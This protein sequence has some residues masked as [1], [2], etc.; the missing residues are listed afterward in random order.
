MSFDESYG[1]A[2]E[3]V[4]QLF[5]D[6]VAPYVQDND[7]IWVHDYHLM[8][9]AKK[10]RNATKDKKNV[11]IGFFLHTA[12]PSRDF[13]TIL[14]K[15]E[16]LLQGLFSCDL[17][18]FHTAEYEEHF[19]NSCQSILKCDMSQKGLVQDGSKVNTG[20]FPIGID[21]DEFRRGLDEPE[22]QD[23]LKKL[24][25]RFSGQR[26]IVGV[27]RMDYIKG[28]PQKLQAFDTFLTAHPEFKENTV[29]VQVAIPTRPDVE[30][31]QQL[32]NE[33]NGLIGKIE[34]KHGSTT[35]APIHFMYKSISKP[36]LIALYAL[37]DV[38]LISSTRDGMNLVSYEYMACQRENLGVLV[39]SEYTGAAETLRGGTLEVNPWHNEE[40]ANAIYDAMSM[41]EE[42]RKKRYEISIEYINKH[43]SFYWGKTFL[44]ALEEGSQKEEKFV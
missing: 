9:M 15:R 14:P 6:V 8:T 21:P 4:N 11:R 44:E 7:L 5:A 16:E 24:K 12:F 34:G 22:V 41:K 35:Y 20:A 36:E 2:Y 1:E 13:F 10:L 39:I 30:E 37:S 43:T 32:R 19:R 3:K 38:C 17:V 29:L 27:D 26:V 25:Q 28:I 31:Y 33:V 42:E 23:M 18:G 40:F